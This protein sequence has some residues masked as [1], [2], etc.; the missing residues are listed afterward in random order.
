MVSIPEILNIAGAYQAHL[1]DLPGPLELPTGAALAGWIDHT[2][3]KPEATAGQVEKLCQEALQYE[4]ASVCINPVFVPLAAKILFNSPVKVCTVIGF[5]LGAVLPSQKAAE[6]L[7]CLDAG[8]TE[9]DM[10]IHI[11]SLKGS[12]YGQVLNEIHAVVETAHPAG[13]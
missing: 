8:A 4:F 10:V 2:L 12:D 13:H 7:S 11:G 6:T 5:P 1:P 9:I 3:L